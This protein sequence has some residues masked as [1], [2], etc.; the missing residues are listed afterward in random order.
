[1]ADTPPIWRDLSQVNSRD[2]GFAQTESDIVALP[3]GGYLIVWEDRQFPGD[4]DMWG[5]RYNAAGD[6]VGDQFS[7][8]TVT[9]SQTAPAL[10]SFADGTVGI[11]FTDDFADL[12]TWVD[13]LDANLN[14]L[15]DPDPKSNSHILRDSIERT[16]WESTDP[17]IS[18]LADGK[19]VVSYTYR[20]GPPGTNDLDVYAQ[21]MNADGSKGALVRVNTDAVNADSA[22]VATLANGNFVTVYRHER[23][24]ASLPG[25]HDVL[26]QIATASGDVVAANSVAGAADTTDASQPDVAALKGGGFVVIWT[27]AAGDSSGQGIRATVFDSAGTVVTSDRQVNST[28]TGNQNDAS[29]IGLADGGFL[30][31]WEDDGASVTRAQRFDAAGT[32]VGAQF[33][34]LSGT[35]GGAPHMALLADGRVAFAFDQLSSGDW[36]VF[37]S[38]WDPGSASTQP[39][40]ATEGNDTLTALPEGSTLNGLGGNDTLIGLD[41]NDTLNGGNGNDV[42]QGGGGLDRLIGG[43]GSDSLTGGLGADSF[44]F[45]AKADSPNGAGRDSILDFS[46]I[47]GDLI[48]LSAIDANSS[49]SGNQAFH[50]VDGDDLS[51]SFAAY[52]RAHG[53]AQWYGVIRVTADNIV[54]A[55][56]NGDGKADFEIAVHGDHLTKADFIV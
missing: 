42:L 14:H 6:K 9:D 28:V 2:G 39:P 13:R 1:M 35:G 41:G 44:V 16:G 10:T 22:E 49:K 5:Q 12:D 32:L 4:T 36:D 40:P 25:D 33:D 31:A 34:V 20:A 48:D 24:R 53:K 50:F 23:D 54:Q 30:V 38:I 7:V 21:V 55:D 29:V 19:Y 27:D 26:F 11:A 3:D 43:S 17:A 45:N 8:E 15:F 51:Q 37:T 47:D 46:H 52:H 56:I 18:T